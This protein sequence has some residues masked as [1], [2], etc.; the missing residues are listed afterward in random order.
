V[1][2]IR[3]GYFEDFKSADTLLIDVDQDGLHALIAWLRDAI[4]SGRGKRSAIV[5]GSLFKPD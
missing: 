1:A 5:L 3:I 4:E 2:F